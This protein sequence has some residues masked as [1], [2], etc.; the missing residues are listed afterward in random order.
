MSGKKQPFQTTSHDSI[1]G[2]V[3]ST[4]LKPTM[5][6]RWRLTENYN[7]FDDCFEKVLEQK[8]ISET[9]YEEWKEIEVVE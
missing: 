8:W 6:L 9:G 7:P 3:L 2:V 4:V 1:S 5:M